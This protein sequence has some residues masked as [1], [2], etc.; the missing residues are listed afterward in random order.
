MKGDCE[1]VVE[2]Y[3]NLQTRKKVAA[4]HAAEGAL[5]YLNHLGYRFK[6]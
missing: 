2:C 4:E 1:A 3:G 6:R 5:W